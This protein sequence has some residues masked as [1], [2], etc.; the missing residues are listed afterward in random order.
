[1]MNNKGQIGTIFKILVGAVFAMAMLGI[2]YSYINSVSYPGSGIETIKTAISDAKSAKGECIVRKSVKLTS[3]TQISA[4]T[5]GIDS[6]ELKGGIVGNQGT[7]SPIYEIGDSFKVNKD[8]TIPMAFK[9][10]PASPCIIYF[11]KMGCQE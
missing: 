2:I 5:L 9:C 11:N 1:M 7:E 8:L 4:S 6:L 3:G 10:S